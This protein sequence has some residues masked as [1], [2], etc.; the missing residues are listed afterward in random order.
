ML[1]G[2]ETVKD[3]PNKV[4]RPVV[5]VVDD[6]SEV[7]E[8]IKRLLRD[9]PYEVLTTESPRQAM[10][11]TAAGRIH[12][13]IA[14]ERMPEMRGT[15]LLEHV[16]QTSPQTVRVIL[17]GYPRSATL[18]YGL[19]DSVEWLI[20]KPWNDDALRLTIRQLL[21]DRTL[22]GDP[23]RDS[24]DPAPEAAFSPRRMTTTLADLCE[25]G[26]LALQCVAPGGRI[27]WSNP[28]A[29]ELL[30]YDRE[31]LVGR[32]LSDLHEDPR[33]AEDLLDRLQRGQ[34]IR[35]LEARLRRRNGSLVEVR[36]DANGLWKEGRFRH[37]RILL[38]D[39]TDQKRTREELSAAREGFETKIRERA[40]A[41]RET[42]EE[43]VREI[44]ERT[45]AE[46][47]LCL[48]EAKFRLLV[49]S[50]KDYAIFMLSVEGTVVSWN[51]GAERIYGYE[52][53]QI[54]GH[55]FT[56]LY[57]PEA[58]EAEQP[59][60][61]LAKAASEGRAEDEGW[62]RRKDGTQFWCVSVITAVRDSSGTLR[63]FSKVTRDNTERRRAEE[64]RSRLNV[65][66]LQGQKLQAIGQLSAGIAHEIN[67]PVGYI[68]SNLSTMGEYCEDL[69][70]LLE[71]ACE[72]AGAVQE[73]RDPSEAL[74]QVAQVRDRIRGDDI[75]R[76]LRDVVAD[77]KLG[78]E[79]IRDI[80][81]S[82]REFSHL[83]EGELR[84]SDLNQCLDAALRICW[85][86]LK[87]KAEIEKDY[88]SLPLIPCYVQRLQQVFINLL[89]NAGQ[90]IEKRGRIWISTRVES[91][92]VV[93]R[94][95]DTGCGIPP[96]N[97]RK[98]FEPFFTTKPVGSGT[99]LG[100]HV[101]H[102][103]ILAHGGRIDVQST[104]GVGSEF[105]VRLPL[106]GPTV[107]D[108]Q[109]AHDVKGGR[110]A[111]NA[112]PL[113]ETPGDPESVASRPHRGR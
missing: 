34:E 100:L 51:I 20:S 96:D 86:E 49:E 61:L 48:S 21:G 36:I 24:E 46:D 103:I 88:G 72:A 54:L 8:S 82:L 28:A 1:L 71:P 9:E 59:A 44:A 89:V 108:S 58:V 91:E 62:R 10:D 26:P 33:A 113:P 52:A 19:A 104:V 30:G 93:V 7:L 53:N 68:L 16:R 79:R 69:R 98:L 76:D 70:Q 29:L 42:N 3:G 81:R 67:N 40:K 106:R 35:N 65:Q 99:G 12:L 2:E 102:K 64:E 97:L 38:R 78:T 75:L 112:D 37:G 87:Y 84:P 92:H 45:R 32:L 18:S 27:L 5:L 43:L 66:M 77:C 13:L 95:R 60:F 107:V 73:G 31:D 101:A 110:Y 111:L 25:G 41:L 55:S 74:R 50:V 80:V 6:Q 109:T 85:N 17:T 105:T 94:V 47:T 15:D 57:P 22:P 14:D 23:D 90:A 63:G 4:T 11:W 83:D 39:A 56:R